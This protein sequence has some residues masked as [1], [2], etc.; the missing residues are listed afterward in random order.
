MR[1]HHMLVYD[2]LVSERRANL[3]PDDAVRETAIPRPQGRRTAY[4]GP[5][6]RLIEEF[7]RLP[8]IGRKSAERL[9][10]HVLKSDSS[11]AMALAR[12]VEDVK[13]SVRHCKVCYNLTDVDPCAVCADA[14]RDRATVL[15]VEQPKDVIALE[16]TG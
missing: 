8:G 12:A 6:E 15:I 14:Q 3:D 10:F 9:A 13:K 7:A 11:T 5:V 16:Q 2:V 4:P 1:E